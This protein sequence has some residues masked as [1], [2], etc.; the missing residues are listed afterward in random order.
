MSQATHIISYEVSSKNDLEAM[1]DYIDKEKYE[2]LRRFEF[3]HYNVRDNYLKHC[4]KLY[5]TELY[6]DLAYY[7]ALFGNA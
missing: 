4:Y 2:S 6:H 3:F 1:R 7:K 5:E